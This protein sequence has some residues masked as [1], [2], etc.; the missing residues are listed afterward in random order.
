MEMADLWSRIKETSTVKELLK[1]LEEEP[2]RMLR[3]ICAQYSREQAPVPDHRL[4]W[5]GYIGE[6]AVRA[7]MEAG[8][9]QREPGGHGAIYNYRPTEEGLKYYREAMVKEENK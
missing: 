7:L 2:A 9:V 6:V 3:A 4:P 1:G 5:A 8:L